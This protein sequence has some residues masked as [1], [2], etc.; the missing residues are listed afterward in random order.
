MDLY[1]IALFVHFVTLVVAT[2]V[3]AVVHL[4]MGRLGRARTVGEAQDWHRVVTASA[5][6][7]P[8]CLAAFV[9]T[10]GYMLRFGT[11]SVWS[12][13]FVVAG[14]VGVALLLASGVTL[15]VKGKALGQFLDGL[16]KNGVD[17]PAPK[18]VPPPLIGA[19]PWINPFIALAVAFDMTTKPQSLG[20]AL[21]VLAIGI[22]IGAAVGLRRTAPA[23]QAAMAASPRA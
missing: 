15:G 8:I 5:K 17:Q 19:L 23:P 6:W 10:G 22:A 16:A 12:S 4:A 13:G 20:V 11:A 7:F 21:G 9:I 1:H 18:L 14:L 2:V 3:S